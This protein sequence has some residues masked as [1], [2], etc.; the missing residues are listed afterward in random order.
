MLIVWLAVLAAASA[1]KFY[2]DHQVLRVVPET[3]GQ[4]DALSE[5]YEDYPLLDFWLEPS[6]T[7]R[8]VDIMV[9]PDNRANIFRYLN[10][11]LALEVTIQIDDVQ[12]HLDASLTSGSAADWDAAY[13]SLEDVNQWLDDLV[14]AHP[15][16]ASKF[17]LGVT[18]ENRT[19]YGIKITNAPAGSPAIYY[20]G[21]IHA[22]EWIAPAVVQYIIGQLVNGYA[23][24]DA[25]I[26]HMVDS[27]EWY[28]TPVFNADGY[29]YTWAKNGDRLWRKNR[30]PGALGCIGTDPCRNADAGFGGPGSSSN[31]C[32]ETYHG[33]SP[34]SV[35]IVAA[36]KDFVSS[37]SNLRGYI[38]FH[39][40]ADA[41]LLPY[42]YTGSKPRDFDDQMALGKGM[43]AAIKEVHGTKYQYG[44]AYST[45]YPASGIPSDWLYDTNDVVYS[46]A[47]ELSGN[48]FTP[49]AT[50]IK[51]NGEEI[52]AGIK[53]MHDTIV[54]AE[55]ALSGV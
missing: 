47:I 20:D 55:R 53:V 45:I 22:R 23:N 3:Q 31:P 41:L 17:E 42:G 14:K 19:V 5:M 13:H 35:P 33:P 7:G 9:T 39:S 36:W 28:I 46:M 52:F 32:S 29:H 4:V 8:A 10:D 50:L 40:Y 51:P 26:K 44:P 25:S 1:L 38:N 24:D 16:I 18:Y 2:N 6:H 11:T 15:D 12:D 48:S 54:K 27:A 49:S 30:Q 43:V 34:F 37:K 21:G